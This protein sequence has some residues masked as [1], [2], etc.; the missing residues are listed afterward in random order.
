MDSTYTE[1]INIIENSVL[2]VQ[3]KFDNYQKECFEKRTPEYFCL[4]LNGEAG[5]L[6]NLEK[7][8]WKGKEIQHERFE[9]EVADVLIALI[10]YCNS[11]NINLGKATKDKLIKIEIKRD[12]LASEG[13]IY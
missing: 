7:K 8:A 9:D 6:A 12:K 3:N 1:L 11:K 10:N 5:E 13:L 2:E 4:E